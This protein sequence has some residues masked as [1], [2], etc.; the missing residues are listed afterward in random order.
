MFTYDWKRYRTFLSSILIKPPV[1]NANNVQVWANYAIVSNEERK[2]MACAPRDM[3]I[4]QIQTSPSSN[5]AGQSPF[6]G[7]NTNSSSTVQS[8]DIRFSHAV[9]VI[10]FGKNTIKTVHSNYSTGVPCLSKEP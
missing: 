9:K 2:R 4:E 6:P 5:F 7:T 3:L 10:F 1:L 8:F